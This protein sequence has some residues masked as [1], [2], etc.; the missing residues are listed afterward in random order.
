[1]PS[2]RAGQVTLYYRAT[3]A[4]FPILFLHGFTS[5]HDLWTPV[6]NVFSTSFRCICMDLRGHGKS[7]SSPRESYSLDAMAQD[8]LRVLDDEEVYQAVIV[9]HSL[10][11]MIGQHLAVHHADRVAG[12]VLSSTT[13]LAPARD[14]FEPLISAAISLAH[15][16]PK[17]RAAVPALQH[18]QPLDEDTAWGCGEAILSLPRYDKELETFNAPALAIYGDEDSPNIVSGSKQLV[19]SI[20]TC[21]E[22]II[23]GG[24]HVPQIT[25]TEAYTEA[26]S[27]FL[28]DVNT[29]I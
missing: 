5:T 3:G 18:S 11:G 9:G 22:S 10:G 27:D 25:H 6:T 4:G 19:A 12:L 13:C 28:Q 21:H 26:L 2:V 7:S 1:M 15:M 17:E 8:A 23:A 20:P 16:S 14:A 24:G 29:E